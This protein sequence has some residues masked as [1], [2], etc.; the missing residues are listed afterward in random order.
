VK[1]VPT[2]EIQMLGVPLGSDAFT[3]AF[4]DKK[5]FNRLN[6][7]VGQLVEFEDTQSALFL[8]RISFGIVRAVHFMR[9]TPLRQWEKQGI[10]FDN[11]IRDAAEQI[12]GF[13]MTDDVLTGE[14]NDDTRRPRSPADDRARRPGLQ[15]ELARVPRN[16]KRGLGS[17]GRGRRGQHLPKAS[18]L[19]L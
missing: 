14:P 12:L 6:H 19:H 13:P 7:T 11:L 15:R 8:L 4:V 1:L 16:S 5:L 10:K 2:N 17:A 18:L 9:T 3:A